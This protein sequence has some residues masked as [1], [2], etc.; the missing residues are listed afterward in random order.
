MGSILQFVGA[1]MLKAAG[2]YT[3]SLCNLRVF[4]VFPVVKNINR[5]VHK[6]RDAKKFTKDAKNIFSPFSVYHKIAHQRELG[7]NTPIANDF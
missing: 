4:F 5:R 6:K 2:K 7:K 1:S 3:C